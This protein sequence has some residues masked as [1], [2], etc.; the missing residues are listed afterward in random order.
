MKGSGMVWASNHGRFLGMRNRALVLCFAMTGVRKNC[1]KRWTYGLARPCLEGFCGHTHPESRE[2]IGLPVYLKITTSLD[3]KLREYKVPY[4]HTFLNSDGVTALLEYID[5]RR[6]CG[7]KPQDRSLIFVSE[8]P[9]HDQPMGDNAILHAVRS[10]A[11]LVPTM[12]EHARGIWPHQLRKTFRR[13]INASPT[14]DDFKTRI[15]GWRPSGS[16]KHYADYQ[17]PD[18]DALKY[19]TANFSRSAGQEYR[20]LVE[21]LGKQTQ[22]IR[23][24]QAQLDNAKKR[25]A[26][27]QAERR[28]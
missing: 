5:F 8:N 28:I 1:M 19:M 9:T 22:Q 18:E 20:S 13:V 16:R 7:W 11:Y 15:M 12:R 6:E 17:N 3:T 21:R 14:D 24:L 27:L 23:D 26:E 25:L 2:L 10:A 4:Y